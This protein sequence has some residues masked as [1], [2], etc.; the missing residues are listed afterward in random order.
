LEGA[1]AL[2]QEVAQPNARL[3]LDT[4]QLTKAGLSPSDMAIVPVGSIGWVELADGLLESSSSVAQ[5]AVGDRRLP[6]EGEF[7]IRGYIEAWRARGYDGPWGVEVMSDALRGLPL[8]EQ[9]RRAYEASRSQF[10]MDR[11]RESSPFEQSGETR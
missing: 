1:I 6:G 9:Y 5:E 7:D 4:W 2:V 10:R 3:L 8:E 11:Y